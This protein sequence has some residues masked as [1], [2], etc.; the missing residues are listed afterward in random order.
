MPHRVT[1]LGNQTAP[2]GGFLLA[3]SE[4]FCNE[5]GK[6][7]PRSSLLASWMEVH[8]RSPPPAQWGSLIPS[9]CAPEGR[10]N[11]SATEKEIF[12]RPA[13]PAAYAQGRIALHPRKSKFFCQAI[14]YNCC[15][16][17][18]KKNY[19]AAQTF[20]C[21]SS[22]IAESERT[23]QKGAA[24]TPFSTIWGACNISCLE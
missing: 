15:F 5:R 3:Q 16:Y 12:K 2:V 22:N 7:L 13:I 6:P 14:G 11:G 8:P 4:N 18:A 1:L 24:F 17:G 10:R 20:F 19:S 23:A 9:L 21:T